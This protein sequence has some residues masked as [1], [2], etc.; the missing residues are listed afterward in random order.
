MAFICCLN[1]LKGRTME[2]L[3]IYCNNKYKQM[4]SR[5]HE[6]YDIAIFLKIEKKNP[7]LI[8]KMIS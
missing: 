4:I 6:K 5:L 7:Y 8:P 3:I 1:N 2:G